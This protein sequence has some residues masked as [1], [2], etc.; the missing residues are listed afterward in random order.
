MAE[1]GTTSQYVKL[2]KIHDGPAEDIQPGELNQPVSVPQLEVHRCHECGQPLPESYEPPADEAWTTGIFGCAEDPESCWKGLF[3][4]CVL[5]G[6]NIENIKDDVRWT[7]ACACHAVFVEGGIAIGAA[8][9]LFY[10]IDPHTSCLIIEGLLFT[11]WM[12][13]V[14]TGVFR[15]M[16][17]RKYHLKNSPCDPCMVHCCMHW[18]AICQEHREMKGHLSENID[19]PTI[20]KPPEMQEMAVHNNEEASRNS[21][22][23][24]N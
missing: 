5:F 18:C 24:Q 16:L 8:M 2:K 9:P 22:A 4:P 11:W 10:G 6:Q 1:H 23:Q 21:N 13:A 17:Q 14:Y 7:T 3:C 15:Q 20:I 19:L 12:C